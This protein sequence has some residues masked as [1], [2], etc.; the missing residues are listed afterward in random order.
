MVICT[1]FPPF[2]SHQPCCYHARYYIGYSRTHSQHLQP[3]SQL[4]WGQYQLLHSNQ[5]HWLQASV[6]VWKRISLFWVVTRHRLVVGYKCFQTILRGLLVPLQ[7]DRW[8]SRY[9]SNQLSVCAACQPRRAQT[10]NSDIICSEALN[11]VFKLKKPT[12]A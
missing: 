2:P 8:L 5:W 11:S 6:A 12:Y 10:S 4:H 1:G 3:P 7:R 9:V